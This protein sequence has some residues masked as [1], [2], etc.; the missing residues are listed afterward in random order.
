MRDAQAL[1]HRW[2]MK[3]EDWDARIIDSARSCRRCL[4]SLT[5]LLLWISNSRLAFRI[6]DRQ[7]SRSLAASCQE[8]GGMS[9]RESCFL[10]WSLYRFLGAP[11]FRFPALSSPKRTAFG[12]R[13]SSILATCPAQRSCCLSRMDLML[14]SWASSRTSSLDT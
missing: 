11:R 6:V 4:F 1:L 12:M 9:A 3:A 14:G 13:E 2:Q 10:S 5:A 8:F 7:V